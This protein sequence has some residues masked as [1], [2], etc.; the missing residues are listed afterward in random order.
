MPVDDSSF[1]G[2][3]SLVRLTG[4]NIPQRA[5]FIGETL[6]GATLSSLTLGVLCGQ[7]GACFVGIGPLVP[8]MVGSWTGY[9]FGLIGQWHAVTKQAYYFSRNY[10]QLMAHCLKCDWDIVVPEQALQ[11]GNNMSD[12]IKEGGIGRLTMAVLAAQ[13]MRPEVDEIVIKERQKLVDD[14]TG[15]SGD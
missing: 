13:T 15:A 6:I 12:W 1:E 2:L 9:T 5:R 7:V 4:R 14:F 3:S 11:N 10:T 8:F